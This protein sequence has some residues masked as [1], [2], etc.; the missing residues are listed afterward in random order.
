VSDP[1]QAIAGVEFADAVERFDSFEATT[2]RRYHKLCVELG[3]SEF[4]DQ[5]V[6]FTFKVSKEESYQKLDHAG[7][8][9]LRSVMLDLRQLWMKRA[10]TLSHRQKHAADQRA[11]K[12][13]VGI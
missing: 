6:R 13:N 2:L 11:R 1:L 12:R 10:H 7:P 9:Q 8:T 5:E 3:E 4:L